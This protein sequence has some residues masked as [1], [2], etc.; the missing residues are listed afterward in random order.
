MGGNVSHGHVTKMGGDRVKSHV[1]A[2]V[3]N[4]FQVGGLLPPP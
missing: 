1:K 4:L 2:V 3:E